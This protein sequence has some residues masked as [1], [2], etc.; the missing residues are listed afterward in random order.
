MFLDLLDRKD[1]PLMNPDTELH[2]NWAGTDCS[3]QKWDSK[4]VLVLYSIMEKH[5]KIQTVL[6][7][8]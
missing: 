1:W 2:S 7:F 5:I 4:W 3:L 8:H 6:S